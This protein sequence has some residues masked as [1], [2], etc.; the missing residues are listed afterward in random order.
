MPFQDSFPPDLIIPAEFRNL[1]AYPND[2]KRNATEEE[3]PTQAD[4]PPRTF[5]DS[6]C[7][8]N[9]LSNGLE[10]NAHLEPYDVPASTDHAIDPE[11]TPAEQLLDV[12]EAHGG[13]GNRASSLSFI[14]FTDMQAEGLALQAPVTPHRLR[15]IRESRSTFDKTAFDSPERDLDQV[16]SVESDEQATMRQ[17]SRSMSASSQMRD[18]Q[19]RSASTKS[20]LRRTST[21]DTPKY[22]VE[23]LDSPTIPADT[24]RVMKQQDHKKQ[25]SISLFPNTTG[26]SASQPLVAAR[27]SLFPMQQNA[28]L[29][30]STAVSTPQAT[31][32]KKK[33]RSSLLGNL[34]IKGL[35]SSTRSHPSLHKRAGTDMQSYSSD[36][37]ADRKTSS[38][39][40][41]TEP[42]RENLQRAATVTP[43]S[44]GEKKKARFLGL[45]VSDFSLVKL[46]SM[47]SPF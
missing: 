12:G 30:P 37:A 13:R 16:V 39:Q 4:Y 25:P 29:T 8:D 42:P 2:P 3:T 14:Q 32:S 35:E 17:S 24:F 41:I 47:A 31:A 23:Q 33:Q 21:R 27:P 5:D 15:H 11:R 7:R 18:R 6:G 26:R 9:P 1:P 40:P 44:L 34:G 10:K 45:S 22:D 46:F 19:S 20:S 38:P 28:P 43:N 36:F